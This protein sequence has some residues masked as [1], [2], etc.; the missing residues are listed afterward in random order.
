MT[1]LLF[2][3]VVFM[4]TR[5]YVVATVDA[6]VFPFS[7]GVFPAVLSLDAADDI[8]YSGCIERSDP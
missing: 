7:G 6:I 5:S 1:V 3:F 8:F 4:D 2:F